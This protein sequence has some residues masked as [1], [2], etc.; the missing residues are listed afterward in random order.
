MSSTIF[1]K[2]RGGGGL[3]DTGVRP[4]AREG[5]LV[6]VGYDAVD[7]GFE[8]GVQWKVQVGPSRMATSDVSVG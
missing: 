5:P 3:K 4:L 7:V 8:K 6:F 2:V 1:F